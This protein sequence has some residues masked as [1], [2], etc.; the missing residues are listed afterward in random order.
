M[1]TNPEIESDHHQKFFGSTLGVLEE[2]IYVYDPSSRVSFCRPLPKV[3][4][5]GQNEGFW[6]FFG[7]NFIMI[8]AL[9]IHPKWLNIWDLSSIIPY[10]EQVYN[11]RRLE[12]VC[13]LQPTLGAK[14]LP[15]FFE[16]MK[17]MR[18]LNFQTKNYITLIILVFPIIYGCSRIRL[19]YLNF[20]F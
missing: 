6:A 16:K 17:K 14:V 10:N 8:T 3:Q 5:I 19:K 18:V 7:G 11:F 13:G 4:K 20:N 2:Q 12:V 15:K 9:Q 1:I